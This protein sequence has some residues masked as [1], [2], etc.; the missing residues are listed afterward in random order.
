MENGEK[1]KEP[2]QQQRQEK[3]GD[4][5]V[6]KLQGGLMVQD[7]KVGSG[8]EAKPGKKIQVYYEGRLKTNN[9][10]FDSTKSGAGFK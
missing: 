5:K 3:G 10:V 8:A 4:G 9:K 1:K 2:Q 6:Q 7:L